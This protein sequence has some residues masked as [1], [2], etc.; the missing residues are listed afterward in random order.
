MRGARSETISVDH[1]NDVEFEFDIKLTA[2]EI[3]RVSQLKTFNFLLLLLAMAAL[4]A[5]GCAGPLFKVQ[6]RATLPPL[7][8]AV[9]SASGGGLIVRVAPLL[10]DE[11]SQDLFEANLP[12]SGVLPIRV[13]LEHESGPAIEIRRARFRLRDAAGREWKL[14]SS[15]AAVSRILKANGVFVYNP[16]SRN[17]FAEEF[18]AYTIDLIPPLSPLD[19]RRQGFLFF[20]T[21]NKGPVEHPSG[22]RLQLER[23][24]EPLEIS[25]N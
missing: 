12:L 22:L 5:A 18:G 16:H 8:G 21:P 14:L 15:K 1:V 23:I 13:E 24:S 11:E 20:E 4:L 7:E 10:E 9:K 6:P 2:C 3:A 19:R 17:Q 25:L